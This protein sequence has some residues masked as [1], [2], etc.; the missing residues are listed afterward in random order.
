M[1]GDW[2]SVLQERDKEVCKHKE[3]WKLRQKLGNKKIKL[4]KSDWSQ[5]VEDLT[6]YSRYLQAEEVLPCLSF[7]NSKKQEMKVISS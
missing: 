1:K 5:V 3:Y 2:R 7:S 6:N 4:T